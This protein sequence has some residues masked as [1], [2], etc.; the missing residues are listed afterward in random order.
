M[1]T[2]I[3]VNTT[4]LCQIGDCEYPVIGFG[5]AHMKR[6]PELCLSSVKTAAEVGYR[7]I[8]TATRYQNFKPIKEALV[9]FDRRH[10]YIISKAWHNAQTAEKIE[11]DLQNCFMQL[12]T[13]YIDA[14][15]LHWPNSTIPIE[16]TLKAMEKLRQ[17]KKI[18]HIGLSNVTV[19][20][21]RRALEVK[22]PIEWVQIEMSPF[23]Y[24]AELLAFCHKH[25]IGIQAA[26]PLNEKDIEKDPLLKSIGQK[27]DKTEAQIALK[28]ILQHGAVPLPRSTNPAHIE[29][30]FKFLDFTLSELEMEEIDERAKK[31]TRKV[32]VTGEAEGFTDEFNFSYEQCWPLNKSS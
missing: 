18:R 19:N 4:G 10:F 20:H 17:N 9:G 5:T 13:D 23:F 31:E 21:L 8:D 6:T 1:S 22:I 32:Q 24:D 7:I 16:E 15:F 3:K 12:G 11:E 28:W 14:Y 25:G 27:Y 2:L 30:N 26:A 29:E